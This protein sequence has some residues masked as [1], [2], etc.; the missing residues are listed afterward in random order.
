MDKYPDILPDIRNA[1]YDSYLKTHG[2][3]GGMSSYS[4]VVRLIFQWKE[5]DKNPKLKQKIYQ[6]D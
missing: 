5:S 6:L 4:A 3:K 1:I 2:V